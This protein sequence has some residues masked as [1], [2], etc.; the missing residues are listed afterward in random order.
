MPTKPTK[1]TIQRINVAAAQVPLPISGACGF[2]MANSRR[3][4]G[5]EVGRAVCTYFNCGELGALASSAVAP[6]IWAIAADAVVDVELG[7]DMGSR[8]AGNG[9][10]TKSSSMADRQGGVAGEKYTVP[11]GARI[12]GRLSTRRALV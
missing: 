3:R 5:F 2:L 1:P 9:V 12:A 4:Y 11:N 6:G 8:V 7:R 10:V